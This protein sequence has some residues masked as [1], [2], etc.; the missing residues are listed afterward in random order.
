MYYGRFS[1][2]NPSNLQAMIDKTLMY[3]QFTMPDP[4]YLGEVVMIAGMESGHGQVPP[5]AQ[6]ETSCWPCS[7]GTAS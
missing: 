1:C 5:V 2:S 3:D 4:S 7:S 6:V